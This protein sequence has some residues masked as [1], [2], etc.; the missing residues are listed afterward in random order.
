MIYA[1]VAELAIVRILAAQEELL[2]K[3]E[4]LTGAVDRLSGIIRDTF[5]GAEAAGR[6]EDEEKLR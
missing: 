6:K 4:D 1:E 2:E 3:Q 5:G